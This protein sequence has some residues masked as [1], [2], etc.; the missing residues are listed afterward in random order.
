MM[1]S[2]MSYILDSRNMKSSALPSSGTLFTRHHFPLWGVS[3]SR[4]DVPAAKVALNCW[5]GRLPKAQGAK[6][7]RDPCSIDLETSFLG[8][9]LPGAGG[10]GRNVLL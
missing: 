5:V 10:S 1:G 8:S 4:S 6:T 3:A 9:L 2:E 7:K